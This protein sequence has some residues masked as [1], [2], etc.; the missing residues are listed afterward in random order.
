VS[1]WPLRALARIRDAEARAAANAAA[2]ARAQALEEEAAARAIGTRASALWR[3]VGDESMA[4]PG[5][6]PGGRCNASGLAAWSAAREAADGEARRLSLE[7]DR[8]LL[9]ARRAE[10]RAGRAAKVALAARDRSGALD[11][12]AAR[13]AAAARAAREAALEREVEE[14]WRPGTAP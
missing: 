7:S 11:R 12:G 4:S 13:W 1:G 8:A 5:R 9:R 6:H 3:E 10:E 14:S 2:R